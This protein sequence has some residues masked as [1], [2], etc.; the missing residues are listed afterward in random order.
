MEIKLRNN[1]NLHWRVQKIGVIG[2]GIV[3]MPMAALLANARI[4]IGQEE[5]AKV[6]VMQRNSLNSG[7][8]V[9]A[10]N[11]GKS[12]IGGIE[13]GLDDIVANCVNEGLL[14]A[15][16]SMEDLYDVDM[17]LVCVQTDKN[18]FEPDY[19]PLFGALHSLAAALQ[20]KPDEKI[21]L[22]VFESTLAPTSML[23]LI[24]DH[25]E[26]YGLKDGENILLGNSPN[27]VMPGRLVERV[28]VSDKLVGGLYPATPVMIKEVYKHIVK[29]GKLLECNSLTA[30]IVKTFENAYRDV[31]IAFAAEIVRYCDE[32][33]ID[34]FSLR[35]KVNKQLSQEDEASD[36][37][38]AVPSGGL[39]VPM[40]GVG[41]HCLPKDGILL[42]WRK[43]LQEKN[44]D[45]LILHA[46]TINDESPEICLKLAEKHFGNLT[47]KKIALLGA[48]YRFNSE[49]TRNSPTLE[50]ARL[51]KEKNIKLVIHDPYVKKDD[52]NLLKYKLENDFTNDLN[53]ALQDVEY[54]F[55]C[56]AHRFYMEQKEVI[57]S[58]SDKRRG[59]MDACNIYSKKDFAETHIK[60]AG[61]GR[62]TK[63]PDADLSGFVTRCFRLMETGVANEMQH[64]IDFFNECYVKDDFNIIDFNKVQ[65]L[66]ATCTTGC[67]LADAAKITEIPEYNAFTPRMIK[68]AQ[69][70]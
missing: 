43:L 48:A 64:L 19:R 9:D 55:M 20:K 31:R 1:K 6:L 24:A 17:V 21:P 69:N 3:G 4:K 66:A 18:G 61:I 53:E 44:P 14:A 28:T 13:P 50:L 67:L 29:Q 40:L 22:I 11:S 35:D 41:G 46:R 37:P 57:M 10:I 65:Y 63:I 52:Q 5:P 39:L 30:E 7:W 62:G 25:F 59:L 47:S 33:N 54:I 2:P 38:N 27:R 68:I 51:L 49:D 70:V 32:K 60:Y 56:T 36:D 58:N 16:N 26:E 8:K 45:S 12:T 23:T 15:T 42:W 34:F